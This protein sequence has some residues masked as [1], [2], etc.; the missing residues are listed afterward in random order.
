MY[1]TMEENIIVYN[2]FKITYYLS[3][4]AC[5]AP[6]SFKP[7]TMEIT[8]SS[9]NDIL[10]IVWIFFI[11]CLSIYG[12]VF[13]SFRRENSNLSDPGQ[14]VTFKLSIPSNFILTLI[15][16][17]VH[18]IYK[19]KSTAQVLETF[20]KLDTETQN[21]QKM[22]N[23]LHNYAKILYAMICIS[24]LIYASWYWRKESNFYYEFV[25]RIFKFIHILQIYLYGK[26][27]SLVEENISGITKCLDEANDNLHKEDCA[28]EIEDISKE[29]CPKYSSTRIIRNEYKNVINTSTFST[30]GCIPTISNDINLSRISHP[31]TFLE[32]SN[33]SSFLKPST[34]DSY[35]REQ[36]T[37]I[38]KL[39][40]RY[41]KVYNAVTM[42]NSAHGFTIMLLILRNCID[43]VNISYTVY[44]FAAVNERY[45]NSN[46]SSFG[47]FLL[48]AFWIVHI[49][50][51]I[52]WLTYC[53]EHAIQKVKKLRDLVQIK[54]LNYPLPSE[55]SEQLKLF[56]NQLFHNNIEFCAVGFTLNSSFL[57][58]LLMTICSYIV[59][60]AQFK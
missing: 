13:T 24:I 45:I 12:L 46:Y 54:L 52:I 21:V 60:L 29:Y 56:S 2:K 58:T 22:K 18:N 49:V 19:R 44:L 28:L 4:I 53:S 20:M 17:F 5:M 9:R 34:T 27:A 23:K 43:L 11:V 42:F 7:Q 50:T 31:N 37:E 40:L 26:M 47:R 30:S 10:G 51:L 38:L 57:C 36:V 32:T 8:M 25:I 59:V 15:S 48:F 55:I 35:I 33:S 1:Q 6:I 41:L 3:K 16:I 39:R 14:V